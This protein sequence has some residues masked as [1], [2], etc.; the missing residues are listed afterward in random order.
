[1]KNKDIENKNQRTLLIDNNQGWR[2]R[3]DF[4]CFQQTI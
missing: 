2:W 3:K 4:L 1:M